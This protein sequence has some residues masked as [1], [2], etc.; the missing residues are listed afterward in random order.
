LKEKDPVRATEMLQALLNGMKSEPTAAEKEA[1][2]KAAEA[3]TQALSQ[4]PVSK[5]G[6]GNNAVYVIASSD[7]RQRDALLQSIKASLS[8]WNMN[9]TQISEVQLKAVMAYTLAGR[10]ASKLGV[11]RYNE[12]AGTW[13]YV[14]EAVHQKAAATFTIGVRWRGLTAS[15]N[16][17]RPIMVIPRIKPVFI[18]NMLQQLN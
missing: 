1:L 11:Y 18:W 6:T 16:M 10:D 15:W 13:D 12:N 5:Q 14:Q 3:A 17:P 4:V 8:K 9:S 2:L 7:V